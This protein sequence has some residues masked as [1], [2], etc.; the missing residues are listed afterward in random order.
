[1]LPWSSFLCTNYPHPEII[2]VFNFKPG[3]LYFW[4]CSAAIASTTLMLKYK[5]KKTFNFLKR[6]S[7]V[8]VWH[9]GLLSLTNT[10]T[11]YGIFL[12]KLTAGK[13]NHLYDSLVQFGDKLVLV[14]YEACLR[15]Q[16]AFGPLFIKFFE[17]EPRSQSCRKSQQ[18]VGPHLALPLIV[19]VHKD[20]LCYPAKMFQWN[21]NMRRSCNEGSPIS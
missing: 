20:R 14:Y 1:M 12:Q 16:A 19:F 9:S 7:M 5:K 6:I 21:K 8:T 3:N 18:S 11:N 17:K 2:V 10:K 15:T 13:I 4:F